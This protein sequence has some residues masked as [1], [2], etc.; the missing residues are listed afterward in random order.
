MS[1]GSEQYHVVANHEGQHSIWAVGG[2]IPAGWNKVGFTGGKDECLAHVAE[3]WTDL[4]PRSVR[5]DV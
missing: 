2:E 4:T 3:V 5:R 1:I